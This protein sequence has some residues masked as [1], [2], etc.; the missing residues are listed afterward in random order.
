M[1]T[2]PGGLSGRE[3]LRLIHPGL[4]IQNVVHFWATLSQDAPIC[5]K[6]QKPHKP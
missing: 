6:D 2:G 5:A 1:D 3:I 4:L